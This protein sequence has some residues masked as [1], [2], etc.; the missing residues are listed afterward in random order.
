MY[1]LKTRVLNVI[2]TKVIDGNECYR[3]ES[4]F[5]NGKSTIFYDKETGLSLMTDDDNTREVYNGPTEYRYEFN[6]VDDSVFE[7]PDISLYEV[8]ED[9]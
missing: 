9:K 7:E 6:R 8:E 2:S 1:V 3:I 4:Y 5:D